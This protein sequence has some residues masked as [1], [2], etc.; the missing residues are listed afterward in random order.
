MLNKILKTNSVN[1]FS[2][3]NQFILA[4]YF[5]STQILNE[6]PLKPKQTPFYTFV[7]SKSNNKPQT[8]KDRLYVWGYAGL[9]ALGK[10]K[11]KKKPVTF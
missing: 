10:F 9:G 6:K 1:Q 5:H 8:Y 3:K 11:N 2:S 4:N 7:N